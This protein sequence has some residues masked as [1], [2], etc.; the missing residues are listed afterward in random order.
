[1]TGARRG[2]QRSRQAPSRGDR[3][4]NGNATVVGMADHRRAERAVPA[5]KEGQVR[6][7]MCRG[8]AALTKSGVLRSHRDV[9]GNPCLNRATGERVHLDVLPPVVFDEGDES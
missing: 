8:A 5:L 7:P 6:C 4:R 2:S 3:S 1:M 9:F